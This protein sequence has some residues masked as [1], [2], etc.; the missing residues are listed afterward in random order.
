MFQGEAPYPSSQVTPTQPGL[1][2][3]Y[4]S[5]EKAAATAGLSASLPSVPRLRPLCL[6]YSEAL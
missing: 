2:G 1:P 3:H 6:G 4:H 5:A